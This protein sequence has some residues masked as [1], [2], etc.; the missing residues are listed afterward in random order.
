MY[1]LTSDKCRSRL[2]KLIELLEDSPW[3]S[4]GFSCGC[5]EAAAP[6]QAELLERMH[7][8]DESGLDELLEFY[9]D[10]VDAWAEDLYP[11]S[12]GATCFKAHLVARLLEHADRLTNQ[13]FCT[14]LHDTAIQVAIDQARHVLAWRELQEMDAISEAVDHDIC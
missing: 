6:C 1:E 3:S 12:A 11:T 10:C 9:R 13:N 5:S 8:G 7:K 4:P 2:P 14:E